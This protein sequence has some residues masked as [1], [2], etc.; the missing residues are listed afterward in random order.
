MRLRAAMLAH[1]TLSGYVRAE[2][3]RQANELAITEVLLAQFRRAGLDRASAAAA[4]HAVVSL[5]V[6]TATIDA[7]MADRPADERDESYRQWRATYASLDATRYPD[8]VASAEALWSG[9]ADD[10]FRVALAA[11]LG[12]LVPGR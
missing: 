10:R 3:T 8:S 9:S 6:G 7:A 4:Y 5:T 2:P 11:L 12:G 1:P